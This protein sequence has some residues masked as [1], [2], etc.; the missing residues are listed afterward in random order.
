MKACARQDTKRVDVVGN[1]DGGVDD[2][3]Q[4][5]GLQVQGQKGEGSGKDERMGTYGRGCREGAGTACGVRGPQ[6]AATERA[7]AA[8]GVAV[9]SR[10][11]KEGGRRERGGGSRICVRQ[12]STQVDTGGRN[13]GHVEDDGSKGQGEDKEHGTGEQESTGVQRRCGSGT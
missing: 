8:R 11:N 4:C 13:D 2:S 3:S 6:P 9:V 10:D 7:S 1:G 12:D 5:V